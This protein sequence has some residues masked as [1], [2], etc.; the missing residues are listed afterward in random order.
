MG[1]TVGFKVR[2]SCI[3]FSAV[4]GT[5]TNQ[6]YWRHRMAEP[7]LTVRG[8]WLTP[9]H[10]KRRHDPAHPSP[11]YAICSNHTICVVVSSPDDW[12]MRAWIIYSI[13]EI[14]PLLFGVST[15]VAMYERITLRL[16][17]VALERPV[18]TNLLTPS[19]LKLSNAAANHLQETRRGAGGHFT[20][21]CIS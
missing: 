15:H 10:R 13:L 20:E 14:N 6:T 11:G 3:A 8:S 2:L 18:G 9:R 19:S 7:A 17:R 5:F 4:V 12:T 21:P 16:R 1:C